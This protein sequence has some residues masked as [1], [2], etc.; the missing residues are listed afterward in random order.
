METCFLESL[1][2]ESYL[3]LIHQEQKIKE[4][5]FMMGLKDNMF[6]ISWFLT[7]AVQVRV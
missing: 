2:A 1:Y 4:G 6:N 7:Y 3:L 5:L